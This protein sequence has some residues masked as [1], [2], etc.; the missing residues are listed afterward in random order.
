MPS[1]GR[2]LLKAESH[3]IGLTGTYS[4]LSMSPPSTNLSSALSEAPS[5]HTRVPYDTPRICLTLTRFFIRLCFFALLGGLCA[6]GLISHHCHAPQYSSPYCTAV[7]G[8]FSPFRASQ[9]TQGG[10][11]L[12]GDCL[13]SVT[14]ARTINSHLKR[15]HYMVSLIGGTG[16]PPM[17]F[18][19]STPVRRNFADHGLSFY[20]NDDPARKSLVED[21]PQ[22]FHLQRLIYDRYH[23]YLIKKFYRCF[24]T[25]PT[26]SMH[27]AFRAA[28]SGLSSALEREVQLSTANQ[29]RRVVEVDDILQKA[30]NRLVKN[31][32]DI[33][34]QLAADTP[35]FLEY[36]VTVHAQSQRILSELDSEVP[37]VETAY[38]KI[39]WW[40]SHPL[41]GLLAH[42]ILGM[43]RQRRI[44]TQYYEFLTMDATNIRYQVEQVAILHD[45]LEI[46]QRYFLWY[47]DGRAIIDDVE[48]VSVPTPDELLKLDD[49]LVD[50]LFT[51]RWHARYDPI[52]PRRLTAMH[53]ILPLNPEP[54]SPSQ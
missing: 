50:R 14:V 47:A 7:A 18:F 23:P 25:K 19:N 37:R 48:V 6:F 13:D 54:S 24:G 30:L 16:L 40:D 33:F 49:E 44:F 28:I 53:L 11:I 15:A 43:K 41:I 8:W 51:A 4:G 39:P 1:P 32:Q 9:I 29:Q 10:C 21:L 31:L 2:K 38:Y 22:F 3:T 35:P 46:L 34:S 5:L 12:H 26:R 20:V 36:I 45:H 17:H 42:D 27:R 52:P